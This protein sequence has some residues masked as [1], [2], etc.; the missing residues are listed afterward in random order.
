LYWITQSFIFIWF[1]LDYTYARNPSNYC[2]NIITP[3][4]QFIQ[5]YENGSER[6]YENQDFNKTFDQLPSISQDYLFDIVDQTASS[7]ALD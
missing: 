5:I 3:P 1:F 6:L 2:N 7:S 4:A